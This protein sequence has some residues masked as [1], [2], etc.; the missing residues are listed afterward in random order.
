MKIT[1]VQEP[2]RHEPL[3]NQ[4]PASGYH[5]FV[6]TLAKHAGTT[7]PRIDGFRRHVLPPEGFII[8]ESTFD[9]SLVLAE[10]D[11]DLRGDLCSR[12]VPIGTSRTTTLETLEALS[13]P[14]AV[15]WTTLHEFKPDRTANR[16]GAWGPFGRRDVAAKVG[17]SCLLLESERYCYMQSA[18]HHDVPHLLA[19]YLA[20]WLERPE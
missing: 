9:P 1:F 7:I 10:C 17:A 20:A 8:L 19:D 2:L 16:A 12:L 14:A 13:L 18:Q 3:A 6:E 15:D 5:P 4:A 11:E